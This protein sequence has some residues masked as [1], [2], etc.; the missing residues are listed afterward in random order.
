MFLKLLLYSNVYSLIYLTKK[1]DLK[2]LKILILINEF[3]ENLYMT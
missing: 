3:K 1:L 2:C